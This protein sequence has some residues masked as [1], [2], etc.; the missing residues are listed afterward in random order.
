VE[1]LASRR[2]MPAL[3]ILV[4]VGSTPA[5][6]TGAQAQAAE[7]SAAVRT[8]VEAYERVWNTHDA[9][10]VA[11]FFSKD[12]DMIIGNGAMVRGR[13]AIQEAWSVYFARQ[14][15]GRSGTFTIDSVRA[16]AP[17]VA[18]VNID[19]RTGGRS[20]NGRE[21]PTRLARGTWV[22]VRQDEGWLI[23]A[24]RALPAEGEMR[25]GPGRDR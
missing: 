23:S 13:Q 3:M 19:S 11:M 2:S 14:D 17:G 22:V 8:T 1:S 5:T 10:A 16:I 20:S 4:A 15:E 21:L 24:L 7:D 25:T 18:V 6:L 12:A 9:S